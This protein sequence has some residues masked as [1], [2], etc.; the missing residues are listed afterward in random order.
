MLIKPIL[1]WGHVEFDALNRTSLAVIRESNFS[2]RSSSV[3]LSLLLSFIAVAVFK[4]FLV[5]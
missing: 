2:V 5:P 3:T 4:S 1:L